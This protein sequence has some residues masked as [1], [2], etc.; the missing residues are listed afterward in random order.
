MTGA[1]GA[2][3]PNLLIV[4]AAK[5]GTTSLWRYL[6]AHPEIFMTERKEPHFFSGFRPEAGPPAITDERKYLELF[7]AAADY[8]LR[9]ETS[10]SYLTSDDAAQRMAAACPDARIVISLRHPIDRAE[11]GFLMHK[12]FSDDRRSFLEFAHSELERDGRYIST[13]FYSRHVSR[14]QALFGERVAIVVFEELVAEP[15]RVMAELFAELG[16]DPDVAARLD[17]T[18]HNPFVVPRNA[19]AARV[20][21]SRLLL[22]AGRAVVPARLRASLD[23]RVLT[24]AGSKPPP[25]PEARALLAEAFRDEV[26]RLEALIGRK[27]PWRLDAGAT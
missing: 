18:Q 26:P 1:S 20:L 6:G 27:L 24:A 19:L 21:R 15:A 7:A 14:Y 2:V 10:P 4:G 9:G 22:G 8:K 11:A 16:V 23:R 13:G 5:A 3:W 12:R 25:D 17:F